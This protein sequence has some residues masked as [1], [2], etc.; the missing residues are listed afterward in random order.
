[1]LGRSGP[2]FFVGPNIRMEQELVATAG[3]ETTVHLNNPEQLTANSCLTRP[4]GL[5]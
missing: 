2:K 3:S 5:D 4:A 1:M